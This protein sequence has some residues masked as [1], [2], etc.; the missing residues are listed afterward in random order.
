MDSSPLL[1]PETIALLARLVAFY[2]LDEAEVLTLALDRLAQE[3]FDAPTHA[4][5]RAMQAQ[6]PPGPPGAPQ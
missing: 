5:A 6:P 3:T 1:S 2:G 4:M